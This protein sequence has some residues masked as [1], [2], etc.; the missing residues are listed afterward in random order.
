MQGCSVIR[1]TDG[2]LKKEIAEICKQEYVARV[3]ELL[4]FVVKIET[5]RLQKKRI[6]RKK[7]QKTWIGSFKDL[8]MPA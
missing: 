1:I 8:Q 7:V 5:G 6:A 4:I 3:P 2:T